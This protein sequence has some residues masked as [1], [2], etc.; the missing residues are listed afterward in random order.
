VAFI[1]DSQFNFPLHL[2]ISAIIIAA[3]LAYLSVITVSVKQKKTAGVL[4]V[5]V[6]IIISLVLLF[7]YSGRLIAEWKSY[8]YYQ[9]AGTEKSS[10]DM[11]NNL[12]KAVEL[13]PD[14]IVAR[15]RLI[16]A[17]L[18]RGRIHRAQTEAQAALKILPHPMEWFRLA[19]TR[20]QDGKDREAAELFTLAYRMMPRHRESAERRVL[21]QFRVYQQ[22]P[23]QAPMKQAVTT[24]ILSSVNDLRTIDYDHPLGYFIEG[25]LAKEFGNVNTAA[26]H[27]RSVQRAV[28]TQDK[29]ESDQNDLIDAA[30]LDTLNQLASDELDK[31]IPMLQAENINK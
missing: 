31:L 16:D 19:E 5:V 8:G 4:W 25:F 1:I 18:S 7:V 3:L 20:L 26:K 30:L 10:D 13:R 6:I 12:T 24:S 21:A 27:F 2:P 29:N 17:Q 9:Q 23:D 28:E 14:N 11:L 22:I 15:R